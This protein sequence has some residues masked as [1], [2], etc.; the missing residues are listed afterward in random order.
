M[1]NADLLNNDLQVTPLSQTFLSEAAK[2]GKFL[3][4]IGFI[5]CGLLAIAAF[6]MPAVYSKMASFNQL[7]SSI[8]GAAGT[9]I[10]I[11]Y[12]V[13]ALLL[14]FPCLYLNKFSTKMRVALTSVSQENFEDSFRNLKSLLKFYG[15]FT[16]VILSFYVLVFLIGMLGAAMR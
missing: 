5:F 12:L 6:F 8:A 15:I 10:T 16:I 4:V 14:F 13:L 9:A 2:W 3:S 1:E 11:V 7:P